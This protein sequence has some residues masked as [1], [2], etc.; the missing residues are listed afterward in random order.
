VWRSRTGS[1]SRLGDPEDPAYPVT[2]EAVQQNRDVL[3]LDLALLAQYDLADGITTT[4]SGVTCDD[5]VAY[6][7]CDTFDLGTDTGLRYSYV[8][9]GDSAAPLINGFRYYYAVTAYDYNSDELAVSRLSLDSGVSF[10]RE[11]SAVPRTEA[12]SFLDAFARVAHVDTTGVVLDDTSSIFV[13]RDSGELDPPEVV[14]ASNALVGFSFTPG[15]PEAVSDSGYTLV[16][17][18]FE[19]VDEVTN[20]VPYRLEDATG[21]ALNAGAD[22][23]FELTYDGRDRPVSVALFDEA[24][25]TRVIFTSELTFNADTAAFVLPDPLENLLAESATGSDIHDSLGTV[26]ISGEDYIPAGYRGTDIRLEWT[27]V[28]AGGDTLTLRV[29]DLD[30]RVAVPFGEGIVDSAYQVVQAEEGSNWSF[31]PVQWGQVRP[32]GRYFVT[33]Q[34]V[35][36]LDLWV[37]GVRVTASGWSRWPRAG[38]VWTL[39]EVSKTEETAV[40]T[41]S[42]GP[43]SVVVDTTV[44]YLSGRRPPVPGGRYRLDTQSGGPDVGRVDLAEIRVVPNPYLGSASWDLGPTQRRLEFIHLPP[45]CTIRIYTISGVLVRVLDHAPEEGGTEVYDL[46]T[47]EGLPL[48]SGNYYYHVTTPGGKTRLG[49]FA[50]VQ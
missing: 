39:R 10:T 11:R 40:E 27:P 3:G 45:E 35:P 42:V 22:P 31:L 1:F 19:R 29:T 16:L 9:R 25:S 20:R 28:D 50:V 26:R 6:T 37:C 36:I 8:D 47:R 13:S 21:V 18:D 33:T 44:T 2:P 14:H 4:S 7:E 49:R 12:S 43:D 5:S 23:S 17:G 48:A 24:D 15:E 38:D 46:L 41:T 30:N 32:G 34:N